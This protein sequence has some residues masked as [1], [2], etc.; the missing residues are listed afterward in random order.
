MQPS[1]RRRYTTDAIK[2]AIQ[3]V[4]DGSSGVD[5]S[6]ET[7]IPYKVLMRHVSRAKKGM[8]YQPQRRGPKTKLPQSVE[9]DMVDWICAMQMDGYP[10]DRRA[11]LVKA[12]QV[13]RSIDASASL[14]DGWYL[15][16]MK[17]HPQLVNRS[18]QSISRAR[19]SVEVAD[20]DRLFGSMATL[21]KKYGLG[22]ERIFNMD[23]TAF[24][25]R[26]KSKNV[27]ALK[28][29]R[30]VWTKSVTTNFHLSIVACGSADG[31]ILPP[32]FIV[33]GEQIN[34]SLTTCSFVEGA[35]VTASPKGFMNEDLFMS[36]IRHF[37]KSIS[38]EVTRPV[39]LVFDG[40]SSHCTQ[41]VVQLCD[42]LQVLLLVLPSN[43][44]HLFQPFD[45]CVFSSLKDTI[46]QEL[47]DAMVNDSIILSC[48]NYLIQS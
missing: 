13:A 14:G 4:I 21:Y 19:N 11:I 32:L 29:S 27:V 22:P 2:R 12:N 8:P 37:S 44:T 9:S 7:H 26:K 24:N 20:V 28:G 38:P 16:F 1:V 33:P 43:A 42:S 30:N 34:R 35:T 48:L 46:R 36:W 3:L 40:L 25:S 23:E 10:V 15:R 6:L 39:L 47:F 45:I 17:R 18:A 31:H 41:E 5:V